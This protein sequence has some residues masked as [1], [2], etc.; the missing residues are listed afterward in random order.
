MDHCRS[1][2]DTQEAL[3]KQIVRVQTDPFPVDDEEA[4]RLRLACCYGRHTVQLV[5]NGLSSKDRCFARSLCLG[6][7]KRKPL[8]SWHSWTSRRPL[9]TYS[10]PSQPRHYNR[11]VYQCSCSRYSTNGG[12]RATLRSPA[13]SPRVVYV[14]ENLDD[15]WRN[16]NIRWKMDNTHFTSIAHADDICLLA[17]SKKDLE[18]MVKECIDGSQAAGLETVLDKTFTGRQFRRQF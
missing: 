1:E 15:G 5:P 3:S 9:T 11:R 2:L 13:R 4:A 17:S 8:C 16:R 12:P 10:T 14:L 7:S 6:E 18:L